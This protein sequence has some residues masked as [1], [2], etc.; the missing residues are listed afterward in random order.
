MARVEDVKQNEITITLTKDEIRDIQK[1][2]S[3]KAI[4]MTESFYNCDI[5]EYFK[6]KSLECNF[7]TMRDLIE[8]EEKV[9]ETVSCE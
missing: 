6:T 8:R 1:V 3:Y 4:S 9:N 2:L 5:K 7:I